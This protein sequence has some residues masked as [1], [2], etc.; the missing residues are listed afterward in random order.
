MYLLGIDQES[1]PEVVPNA[2]V[3][4]DSVIRTLPS[5]NRTKVQSVYQNEFVA[6]SALILGIACSV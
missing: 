2:E 3:R 6:N 1:Y 4:L 5:G